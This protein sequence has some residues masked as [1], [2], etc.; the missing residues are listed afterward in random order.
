MWIWLALLAVPSSGT[1][2]IDTELAANRCGKTH[3]IFAH[4]N[5]LSPQSLVTFALWKLRRESIK[6]CEAIDFCVTN[7]NLVHHYL[8]VLFDQG[9]RKCSLK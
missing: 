5:Q 7:R 8:V 1:N 4:I 2:P 6:S 3:Q 9:G